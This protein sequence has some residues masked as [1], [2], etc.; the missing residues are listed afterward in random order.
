MSQDLL[1]VCDCPAKIDGQSSVRRTGT[2]ERPT[3]GMSSV[4]QRSGVST[5][6]SD[7]SAQYQMSQQR[8]GSR[9]GSSSGGGGARTPA[10]GKINNLNGDSNPWD[11]SAEV[12]EAMRRQLSSAKKSPSSSAIHSP[13]SVKLRS[14][15]DDIEEASYLN[16]SFS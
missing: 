9:G 16:D 5:I 12:K 3:T 1:L 7:S 13:L 4:I 15:E 14:S 8:T 10:S 11:V 6:I 2:G